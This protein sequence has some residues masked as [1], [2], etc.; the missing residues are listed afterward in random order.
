MKLQTLKILL[1]YC[2]QNGLLIDQMD[3]E[4]A[5][6]NGDILSEVYVN[7][8]EGYKKGNDKVYKL[9]KSLYG[10]RESPRSWYEC[11]NKFMEQLKLKR[12]N[13]DYCMYLRNDENVQI[14][15]LL[16][17]DDILIC[18]KN[19]K[20]IDDLKSK[21]SNRF[22]MKDMGKI[23]NY[24]G[25]NVDYNTEEK[26]MFLSQKKYII[27]LAEKYNL[28]NA[29]LYNTP[30][31]TNLK[32]E[33]ATE[34]DESVKFRNIIGEL[35]YISTGTRPDISYSVNYLSRFQSCYDESHFKY[36]L[37]ILK[38]LY[39]T[40]DIKLTYT[41]NDCAD[42]LDCMVDADWAGDCNDRKSTTGYAIRLFNNVVYWKSHKQSSVTKSSTFA[43]YVALSE[44]V[45]D[46]SFVRNMIQENFNILMSNPVKVYEDNSGAVSIARYGNYTKN[47]KHIEVQYHYVNEQYEKGVIDII[48]VESERNIADIFTKSL[49]RAKFEKCRN[50]LKLL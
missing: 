5:F 42:V 14:Y 39:A 16:F 18:S 41:K 44:A 24:I 35:L 31:E 49:C 26:R 12:S 9:S 23:K 47:S 46:V 30:M 36:A 27:S 22:K 45:T 1:S 28:I 29:K 15:V 8:P 33:Q 13:Y 2:C 17:V 3:V 19:Q 20:S 34:I 48:K 40:K 4:T 21:L 10:L 25:I 32:L 37:R 11:F 7:Q 38:Y 50:M 43:E 6:L